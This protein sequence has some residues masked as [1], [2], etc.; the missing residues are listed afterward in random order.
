VPVPDLTFSEM[1]FLKRKDVPDDHPTRESSK[2]RKVK[3]RVTDEEI[4]QYFAP[5]R[6]PL[7]EKDSNVPSKPNDGVP[8]NRTE[9][10]K[11]GKEKFIRA[12]SIKPTI[13]QRETGL[14]GSGSADP[15]HSSKRPNQRSTTYF[16]WSSSRFNSSQVPLYQSQMAAADASREAPSLPSP[17]GVQ[18]KSQAQ[19]HSARPSSSSLP[20][21]HQPLIPRREANKRRRHTDNGQYR[22]LAAGELFQRSGGAV[23]G[24]SWD[25]NSGG[26]TALPSIGDVDDEQPYVMTRPPLYQRYRV[27][28]PD[29]PEPRFPFHT[30]GNAEMYGYNEGTGGYLRDQRGLN[31]M[32]PDQQTM[33]RLG[34]TKQRQTLNWRSRNI[35]AGPVVAPSS[36]ERSPPRPPDLYPELREAQANPSVEDLDQASGASIRQDIQDWPDVHSAGAYHMEPQDGKQWAE[37]R[38]D[39]EPNFFNGLFQEEFRDDIGDL[40]AN[41]H[42]A[43]ADT[44]YLEPEECLDDVGYGLGNEPYGVQVEDHP[45]G[46]EDQHVY[47]EW[48]QLDSGQGEQPTGFWRPNRLY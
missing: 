45:A 28:T 34:P 19:D 1:N 29:V 13:E 21:R 4:S 42:Y 16:T 27:P 8:A 44:D 18:N 40:L 20:R 11:R 12:P 37:D 31:R 43:H 38:H 15:R 47:G 39:K 10:A 22:A 7:S 30:A 33:P 26:P 14:A 3:T 41:G 6:A 46:P 2:K 24:T 32:H 23:K 35:R 36:F 25:G 17:S 5:A 9:T 48:Q